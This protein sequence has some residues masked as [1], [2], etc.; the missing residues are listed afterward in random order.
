VLASYQT[1]VDGPSQLVAGVDEIARKLRGKI[2]ESLKAVQGNPPLAQVSTASID[3]LRAY[4]AGN[5]AN[6][7]ERDLPKAIRYLRQAVA[8]DTGFAMA[9]RKLGVVLWNARQP[10]SSSD[11]AL[12]RAYRLRDRLTENERLLAEAAY[13]DAGP[14]RDLS[15]ALAAYEAFMQRGDSSIALNNVGLIYWRARHDYPRAESAL[16]RSI[17]L[18]PDLVPGYTNLASTLIA[19]G[20]LADVPALLD[21]LHQRFLNPL[22]DL[23]YRSEL[24][25]NLGQLPQVVH[26]IDSARSSPNA[27]VR[28]WAVASSVPLERLRGRLNEAARRM[29]DLA[30]LHGVLG[31]SS[32]ALAD[33]IAM[34]LEDAWFRGQNARAV[35]RLDAALAAAPLTTLPEIDRQYASAA[36]LYAIAGRPDKAKAVMARLPVEVKDTSIIRISQPA[37]DL[38]LGEIALADRK[39]DDAIAEFRKAERAADQV[40]DVSPLTLEIDLARAFDRADRSD[41]AIAHF[42]QY[43]QKPFVGRSWSDQWYLAGAYK[44]LGELYEAKGDR[45]KAASYY[46][47]FVDLW[48]SADPELQPKVAE[49]RQRLA[50]L[51]ALER[52]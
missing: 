41:S 9:W 6:D 32:P 48:K 4:T 20:R 21:Q 51:S 2:G 13:F 22:A 47:R 5:R 1:T 44:R 28:R 12:A 29:T 40:M 16:V 35:R 10:A 11:S 46:A 18:Q 38:A 26:T 27:M 45:D 50:R 15:K 17:R 24:A 31:V 7:F 23:Q 8:I 36:T 42:E 37:V 25:Y 3:A 39:P 33:T 49:V 43:V 34:A 14:G 30:A 19:E 52:K